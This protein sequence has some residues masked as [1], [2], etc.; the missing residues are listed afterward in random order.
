MKSVIK[1]NKENHNL[2]QEQLAEMMGLSVPSKTS[3]TKTKNHSLKKVITDRLNEVMQETLCKEVGEYFYEI[4]ETIVQHKKKDGEVLASKVRGY[5]LV[6]PS[7]E[8]SFT[9]KDGKVTKGGFRIGNPTIYVCG[10]QTQETPYVIKNGKTIFFNS[11][12][13]K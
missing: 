3:A 12:V 11:I 8:S 10:F 7:E 2:T 9:S 4:G 5:Q 13:K 6:L 1:N